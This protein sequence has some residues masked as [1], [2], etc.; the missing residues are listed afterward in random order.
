MPVSKAV[1]AP[2]VGRIVHYRLN[3][4]DVFTITDRRRRV[5]EA[6]VNNWP[7]QAFVGNEVAPGDVFPALVV[8]VHGEGDKALVN[9]RV[10]LDGTDDLWATSRAHGFKDGQWDWP[11][12]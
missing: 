3:D 9:L 2:T 11:A 8:A 12:R 7:F 10:M 5:L 1:D 4:G 6:P